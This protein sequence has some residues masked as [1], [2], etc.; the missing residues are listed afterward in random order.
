MKVRINNCS[1]PGAS[2]TKN[3]E[4]VV[5]SCYEWVQENKNERKPFINFRRETSS[6]KGFNDNNAR[7]IYPMLLKA[8]LVNYQAGAILEYNKFFTKL[9]EAYVKT[10]QLEKN[11]ENSNEYDDKT[12][13][14]ALRKTRY[15]KA[16]IIYKSLFNLLNTDSNYR[17]EMVETLKFLLKYQKIN[18]F[19]FAYLLYIFQQRE[20]LDEEVINNYRNKKLNIE[21]EVNVRND[22][23]L[24]ERHGINRNEGIEYLTSY[25][26]FISLFEQAGLVQKNKDY[27]ISD[28]HNLE[29]IKQLLED[30]KI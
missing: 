9:G 19:E 15:V 8:N 6:A 11:I 18:K 24:R 21:V 14:K 7:N 5:L 10:I 17:E 23:E 22:I 29:R 16:D 3:T 20:E 25:S 28:Q 30:L 27:F 4:G 12:K 13:E 26:Y 2:F 1:S